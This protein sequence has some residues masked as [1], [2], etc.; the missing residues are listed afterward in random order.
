MR[1]PDFDALLTQLRATGESSRFRLLL[2]LREGELTVTELTEILKQSQPRVSRH[3]KVLAE[4]GLVVRFQEGAWVF[5]RLADRASLGPLGEVIFCENLD[6]PIEDKDA[7]DLIRKR[8]ADQAAAYFALQAD[9]WEALRTLHIADDAVEQTLLEMTDSDADIFLD[10]GTGTGRMLMLFADHYD[11]GIGYDVSPEML[12]IARARVLEAGVTH[13]QVRRSDFICDDLHPGADVV[14][15]HHVLHYLA[16]PEQ[17]IAAAASVLSPKG[18]I[19]IA[20]FAPHHREDLRESHAHRR[21]GFHD[22]EIIS[23]AGLHGL[24]VVADRHLD[25]P[26]EGGLITRVWCLMPKEATFRPHHLSENNKVHH[27]A[28]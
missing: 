9:S 16:S 22:H 11:Q 21:L 15:L 18:R 17:A 8:R 14:C 20:D 24:K 27:A 5:Y 12:A 26:K 13:A 2:L 6:L 25:P 4:A 28:H 3:L 1:V 23:W 10:L 19:L 7:L